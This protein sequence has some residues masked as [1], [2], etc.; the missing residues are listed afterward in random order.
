M[1]KEDKKDKKRQIPENIHWADQSAQR[2]IAIKGDKSSYTVASGITPSG[3]IHLGNFREIIT[4]DLIGRA[5]KKK[6]KKV[7]FI[8]S[9]DN[10]DVFRKVPVNMPNQDL[11]KTFLRKPITLVPD[12][13]EEADNYARRNEVAV[14]E[15]LPIVGIFPEFINQYKMYNACTYAENVKKALEETDKIKAIL[16]EYRKEPLHEDWLPV[17]IFCEACGKDTITKMEYKGGTKINYKCECKHEEELDFSEK[18]IIKLK[19]RIDWPMRWMYEDVDFEAAGKDHFA[20]GGSRQSGVEI[21]EA[22]WNHQAPYGFMYE[23]IKIKGG[24]QFSSSQGVAT[25]LGDCLDIY[26]PEIVRYIFAGSRPGTEFAISFDLDAIKMYEDFDKCERIYYKIE[27]AKNEKTFFQ[28]KRIYELSVIDDEN[29]PKK[30]PLQIAFRHLTNILLLNE[31]DVDKTLEFFKDEIKN[32][33]DE[34]RLRTRATCAR[35]WLEKYAPDDFKWKVQDKVNVELDE[36]E[37]NAMHALAEKLKEKD[38]DEKELHN[39]IYDVAKGAGLEPKDFFKAAYKLLIDQER[40]PK[41][42]HFLLLLGDRAI[43]LLEKA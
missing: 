9:W 41:L 2:I 20:A 39:I 31:L 1:A 23:W 29:I 30:M 32:D 11:L 18:G 40:G 27:E 10:Y 15:V 24:K 36:K 34:K 13:T 42:A 22:V 37:K 26:E 8:Y 33:V 21:C 35:N 6:G 43:K 16:D 5:L 38:W 14:E 17:S 28:Q 19:W 25:T 7:R 3:T 4:T 12:T